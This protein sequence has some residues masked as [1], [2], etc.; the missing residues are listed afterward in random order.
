MRGGRDCVSPRL[1]GYRN[2]RRPDDVHRA[3]RDEHNNAK[4]VLIDWAV[5]WVESTHVPLVYADVCCGKGGD[6]PK[7]SRHPLLSY[8]GS[9]VV[10]EAVAEARRRAGGRAGYTFSVRD[11]AAH[12]RTGAYGIVSVQFALHHFCATRERCDGF[13]RDVARALRP[14][15]VFIGTTVR[16]ASLGFPVGTPAFGAAYTFELEGCIDAAVEYRVPFRELRAMCASHGLRLCFWR[17][18]HDFLRGAGEPS[19]VDMNEAY[20]AFAFIHVADTRPAAGRA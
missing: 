15:G 10:S 16:E 18:L 11:G 20:I 5:W 19:T 7:V 17:T 13:V 6:V 1:H 4:R 2:V 8:T 3:L 9:D 14:G 12:L